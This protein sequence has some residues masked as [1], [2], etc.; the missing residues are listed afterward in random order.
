MRSI[1]SSIGQLALA[2]LLLSTIPLAKAAT[3]PV[4]AT[5]YRTHCAICHD[6]AGNH[7]VPP[8]STLAQLPPAT[9]QKALESGVMRPQGALLTAQERTDVANWLS[10]VKNPPQSAAASANTCPAGQQ[11]S[12]G[13]R[14]GWTAWGAGPEN[15]RYQPD[16]GL[17]PEA[18]PHLQ[19][20]WA[21]SVANGKSM[22]SQP[23]VYKGRV[24]L[25]TE[26]GSVYALDARTGCTYWSTSV[27]NVRSGLSIG[28][29]GETEALFFG[30]VLGV[31]HALDLQTGHVLWQT[32]VGDS[33]GAII[34]GAPTYSGG[35]LYVPMSSY[36]EAAVLMPGYHCCRFRGSVTSLD[37]ATGKLL[38]R[39]YTIDKEATVQRKNAA[40][41][42]VLGPA[43]AAVWSAPTVD[44]AHHTVYITTGDNYSDPPT[45]TSDAVLAFDT[46][47]G[48]L[49][50]SKQVTESDIYNMACGKP[51][52][53]SCPQGSGPD[54]DFGAPPIL[55]KLPSGKRALLLGQKS[56][57]VS[58][59][60]PDANG[61]LL[62]Q[63]RAGKGSP[64]GGIE[65]GMASNGNLLFAAVSDIGFAHSPVP[66]KLN[67]DPKVGGGL[68]A[69][70]VSSGKL[71]WKA[72]PV[73]ACGGRNNCSPA[74]SAAI[75]AIDGAVFSGAL[76]GH[77]RAYS[78]KD[79][80]V[81]WDFDTV[82]AFQTV[83]G[84]PGNGGSMDVAGPV[85]ADGMVF[86]N[87]GYPQFGGTQGNVF[88]AF[89]TE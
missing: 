42:D 37:A 77:I 68:S 47:T 30:D 41:A 73:L 6:A 63:A 74:Q 38:W 89:G 18:V 75:T 13:A 55:V 65:W 26:T 84:V 67:P 64:L 80:A 11:S 46:E 7:R 19:L 29:V 50:W 86:V 2:L 15:H 79:G 78:S 58:A 66:G 4:G 52:V 24:Y 16:S 51:G 44:A 53:G 28:K 8:H 21:F 10:S 31:A 45:A 17:T 76:D 25:G 83:N 40:G 9:I 71:V 43:G 49:L 27:K 33:P 34:T 12:P 70:S 23:A 3:E 56:G 32:K 5:V 62:W 36:E 61:K 1:F 85:I 81:L 57:M 22:R 59:V 14:P 48:K 35:R 87:S 88:L 54:F 60:D 39:A 69:F 20:K 72:A 82:R